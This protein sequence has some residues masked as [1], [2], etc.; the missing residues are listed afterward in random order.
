MFWGVDGAR[1]DDDE[2]AIV[3]TCKNTGSGETGTS[4]GALGFGRGTNFVAKESGLKK[5][6]VLDEIKR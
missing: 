5:R 3:M 2:N 1:A 4:N 6:V